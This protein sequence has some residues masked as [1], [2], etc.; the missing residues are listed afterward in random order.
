MLKWLG[1]AALAVAV[2]SAAT[3]ATKQVDNNASDCMI[4]TK[5]AARL[6]GHFFSVCIT[7]LMLQQRHVWLLLHAPNH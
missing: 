2:A 1:L 4:I 7:P 5:A 6:V 3:A